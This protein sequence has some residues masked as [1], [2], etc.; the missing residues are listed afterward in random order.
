MRCHLC[1]STVDSPKLHI[2]R[3]PF[4][5]EVPTIRADAFDEFHASLCQHVF[6]LITYHYHRKEVYCYSFHNKPN[7]GMFSG[8]YR[9]LFLAET[10]A[11]LRY[12]MIEQDL[13]SPCDCLGQT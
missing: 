12:I 9:Y 3:C 11:A 8:I 4:V 1:K 2:I 13:K 6:C 7:G 5:G 10:C